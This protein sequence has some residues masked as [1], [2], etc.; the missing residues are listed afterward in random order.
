MPRTW[1]TAGG[2][3]TTHRSVTGG[4]GRGVSRPVPGLLLAWSPEGVGGPDRARIQDRMRVG[5]SHAADWSLS[6]ER[7]SKEHFE[8]GCAEGRTSIRDLG[9]TNGTFVNGL[10]LA[11]TAPLADQDVV[12]A[13]R[14]VFV[15]VADIGPIVAATGI[16][17]AKH[18]SRPLPFAGHRRQRRRGGSN[19][20]AP[21]GRRGIRCR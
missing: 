8:V 4:C 5:R 7:L 14:C 15:F 2:T 6:D 11:S 17:A 1:E 20:A 12:R 19:Q 13:G 9:S 3:L 21:A 16:E 10:R 18:D